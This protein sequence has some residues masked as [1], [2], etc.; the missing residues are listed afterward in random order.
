[1]SSLRDSQIIRLTTASI[2][3]FASTFMALMIYFGEDSRPGRNGSRSLV[4]LQLPYTRIIFGLA[5]SDIIQSLGILISPFAAPS[6]TPEAIFARGNT[7][8]CEFAGFLLSGAVAVPMYTVLLMFYFFCRVRWKL[9]KI[10]FAK[11][12]EKYGHGFIILWTLIGALFS[13]INGDINASR[14]GSLC[15]MHPYPIGCDKDPDI[16]GECTR[17]EHSIRNAAILQYG[18]VCISFIL[19]VAMLIILIWTVFR[20]ERILHIQHLT[21]LR[22]RNHRE[23]NVVP[24][25]LEQNGSYPLTR[26][27]CI[28][29][30]LYISA[31]L[32]CY[33]FILINVISIFVLGDH[34]RWTFHA[35]SLF[36]PSGGLFNILIYIRPKV[37]KLKVAHP[38]LGYCAR[39][40]LVFLFGGEAPAQRYLSRRNR[41]M[42]SQDI[43][44]QAAQAA[45]INDF[46]NL[47]LQL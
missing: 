16:Y 22:R 37:M 42:S 25:Q 5:I 4:G 40:L 12:Y 30:C 15:V 13:T 38:H 46:D 3:C 34:P 39:V 31:F 28:Q 21:A 23:G 8:S 44:D 45:A 27:T 24:Q 29:A 36:W 11:R 47:F 43:P 7:R 14:Y 1:M 10:E 35:I 32:L 2:S 9:S 41:R 18:P 19:L 33:I 17:G 6:D 20:E 26:E